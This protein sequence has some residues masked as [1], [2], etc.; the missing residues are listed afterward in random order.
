MSDS[1]P[2]NYG[3]GESGPTEDTQSTAVDGSTSIDESGSSSDSEK[4]NPYWAAALEGI[5]DEFHSRLTPTFKEWD[6][7]YAKDKERLAQYDPYKP[8]VEHKVPPQDIDNALQLAE[9]YRTSPRDLFDY[10][11][12]QYNFTLDAPPVEEPEEEVYDLNGEKA[13]D[14]E[15]DPRFQ[16]V[17]QE[18][19]FLRQAYEAE[20][21]KRITTEM[22]AQVDKEVTVVRERFPQL[23]IADVATMATGMAQANGQMPNLIQAAEHM[24]KYLP[25]ERASDGAPSIISGNRGLPA[26]K[27]NFGAMSSDERSAYIVAQMQ[28][29]N[30]Q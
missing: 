30:S 28:A 10:L 19:A 14:L 21:Q 3:Q 24:S 23:D 12:K 4:V 25:K 26:S 22:T 27:N 11:Q 17:T 6:S 7:N 1:L 5:P 15:K 18:T 8:F 9:I 2:E 29:M 16:Q 20:Q 13:Y